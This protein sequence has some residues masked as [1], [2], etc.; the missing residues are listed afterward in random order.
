MPLDDEGNEFFAPLRQYI[1][2]LDASRPEYLDD[3]DSVKLNSLDIA[4]Y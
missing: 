3:L 4:E 2:G 1:V